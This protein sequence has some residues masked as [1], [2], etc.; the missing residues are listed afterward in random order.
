M[1]VFSDGR[2]EGK[3]IVCYSYYLMEYI[4]YIVG[5]RNSIF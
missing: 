4:G 5:Y 3:D 2:K 1:R